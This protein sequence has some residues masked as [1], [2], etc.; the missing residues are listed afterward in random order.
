MVSNHSLPHC[1][2]FWQRASPATIHSFMLLDTLNTDR[3]WLST[4]LGSAFTN[5]NK[6]LMMPVPQREKHKQMISST[7]NHNIKLY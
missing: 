5:Q 3:L 6:R 2:H 4:A 7:T 1:L